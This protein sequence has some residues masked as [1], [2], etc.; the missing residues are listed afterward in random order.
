M[1]FQA[2]PHG[3]EVVLKMTQN[4]IPAVNVWNVDVGAAPNDSILE[5]V[6][7]L[8]DEWITDSYSPQISNTVAFQELIVTD[9]SVEG[10]HQVTMAPT[11][12]NG[13]ATGQ[14]VPANVA[15]VASLRTARIGR[16]YRGRTY[17]TGLVVGHLTDAHSCTT[18]HADGVN[19]AFVSL[20][21]ALADAGYKLA[22]LSRYLNKA[23][24]VVGVLTEIIQVITNT[25]LDT[26]RRRSANG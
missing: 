1:A 9:I 17:T 20:I 16:S 15:V 22:V 19:A 2:V 25:T 11:T 8:F 10:G 6:R 24:R 21:D 4:A 26:Q 3:V 7:D 13:A 23:L 14:S 18:S 5:S 12:P